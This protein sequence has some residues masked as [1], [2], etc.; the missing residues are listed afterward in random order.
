MHIPLRHSTAEASHGPAGIPRGSAD[1]DGLG[2]R[3]EHRQ[4]WGQKCHRHT[5]KAGDSQLGQL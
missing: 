5:M 2:W 3:A 4:G 1:E